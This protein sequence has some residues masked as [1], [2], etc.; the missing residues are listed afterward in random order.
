VGGAGVA[1]DLVAPLLFGPDGIEGLARHHPDVYTGP[2]ADL[3]RALF[4]PVRS[5]VLMFYL[6]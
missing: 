6:A 2:S 5:D 3:F 1:P 4:P